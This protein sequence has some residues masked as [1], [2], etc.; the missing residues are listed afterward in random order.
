MDYPEDLKPILEKE[1]NALKR[2]VETK[3]GP[4]EPG[5]VE[6]YYNIYRDRVFDNSEDNHDKTI[7]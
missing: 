7:K 5:I 6:H 4:F 2:M 3:Q 1:L